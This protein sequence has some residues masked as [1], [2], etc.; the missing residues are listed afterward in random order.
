MK[1]RQQR[2]QGMTEYLIIVAL[3]GVAAIGVYNALGDVVRGQTSAAATALAGSNANRG[4][5]L[6]GDA[7]G[8]ADQEGGRKGLNNFERPAGN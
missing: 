7:N 5:G 2:G 8:R 6:V 4:R 3:I 1:I